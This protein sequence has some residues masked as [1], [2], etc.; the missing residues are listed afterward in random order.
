[1]VRHTGAIRKQ[2]NR[3]PRVSISDN[4]V[5]GTLR[6]I[7]ARRKRVKRPASDEE[8]C[9]RCGTLNGA[10]RDNIRRHVARTRSQLFKKTFVSQPLSPRPTGLRFSRRGCKSAGSLLI[11]AC[12]ERRAIRQL[13]APT[14]AAF[15]NSRI[16]G[17][18]DSRTRRHCLF[19]TIR[20]IST[21]RQ[22]CLC[23]T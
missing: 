12:E 13:V 2:R 1:M 23:S 6:V 10:P 14:L 19:S 20:L 7:D 15:F 17:N 8:R 16:R 21:T 18:R 5:L 9:W 22:R 4:A 11:I 3:R